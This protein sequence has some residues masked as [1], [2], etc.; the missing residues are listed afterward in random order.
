MWHSLTY[1]SVGSYD[2]GT[3][4]SGI[5]LN[6]INAKSFLRPCTLWPRAV[7]PV[8]RS[9]LSLFFPE[10]L[11]LSLSCCS[12]RAPVETSSSS[13]RAP[14][15]PLLSCSS[16]RPPAHP[17]PPPHPRLRS[18]APM[19]WSALR[20]GHAPLDLRHGDA[21]VPPSSSLPPSPPPRAESLNA[22]VGAWS[23]R[24]RGHGGSRRARLHQT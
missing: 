12:P 2:R 24:R 22:A 23:A 13:P 5:Y 18:R 10:L 1:M 16:P 9:P 8:P 20:R 4:S 6:K 15:L 19:A 3:S 7:Y 14:L 11:S 21:G 17:V